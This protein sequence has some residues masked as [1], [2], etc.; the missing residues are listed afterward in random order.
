MGDDPD[1]IVS[2]YRTSDS[3]RAWILRNALIAEGIA[4]EVEGDLQGGYTGLFHGVRLLVRDEMQIRE[5]GH[6]MAHFLVN[7]TKSWGAVPRMAS[8]EQRRPKRCLSCD[9]VRERVSAWEG[10]AP[11]RRGVVPGDRDAS[12]KPNEFAKW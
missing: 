9:P 5:L 7:R 8:V 3:C 1:K 6:R 12:R 10:R 11:G 4:C 2:I